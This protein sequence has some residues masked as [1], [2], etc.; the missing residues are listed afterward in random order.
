MLQQKRTLLLRL[1]TMLPPPNQK[2]LN[3]T[4]VLC[5]QYTIKI[6]PTNTVPNPDR[7]NG[8]YINEAIVTRTITPIIILSLKLEPHF[9]NNTF[10]LTNGYTLSF[11]LYFSIDQSSWLLV[12]LSIV[13]WLASVFLDLLTLRRIK[14]KT[15]TSK[16]AKIKIV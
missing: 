11:H 4:D 1:Y 5:L 3:I 9:F 12:V 2:T 6:L 13:S 14:P 8:E 16:G 7:L 15:I 10:Q